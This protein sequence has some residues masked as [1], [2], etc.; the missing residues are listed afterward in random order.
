MNADFYGRRSP[1]REA[2]A[3]IFELRSA[4]NT[5]NQR[6]LLN[7]E[8]PQPVRISGFAIDMLT[9]FA[10][11]N[12]YVE[13]GG[14]TRI[15][16]QRVGLP[17]PEVAQIFNDDRVAATKFIIDV[18]ATALVVGRNKLRFFVGD[19]L[20][21]GGIPFSDDALVVVASRNQ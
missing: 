11:K 18:P 8:R 1:Q 4:G 12:V 14:A 6:H 5:S 16:A 9:G 15:K 21:T 20:G 7:L 3:D 13:V 10:A 19:R 17:Y 2:L